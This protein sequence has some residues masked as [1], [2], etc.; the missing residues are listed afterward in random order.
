MYVH[1]LFSK[2]CIFKEK[3]F[4]CNFN[5]LTWMLSIFS[6]FSSHNSCKMNLGGM[7]GIV[8]KSGT[9]MK[10]LAWS[11]SVLHLSLRLRAVNLCYSD[12]ICLPAGLT[13][14]QIQDDSNLSSV[15]VLLCRWSNQLNILH[16]SSIC[17]NYK[18]NLFLVVVC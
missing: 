11:P 4:H 1:P 9:C 18:L 13:S 6:V 7:T 8:G 17:L 2:A 3:F 10:T 5:V 12:G 16:D 14:K 15:W